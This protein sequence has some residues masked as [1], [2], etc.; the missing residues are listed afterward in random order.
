MNV[1]LDVSTPM[2]HGVNVDGQVLV[3]YD[4]LGITVHGI[5]SFV[6]DFLAEQGS[7]QGALGAYV[8]AVREKGFPAAEHTFT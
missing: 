4:M 8:G 5:P 3:L 2:L 7:V 1:V 6:R